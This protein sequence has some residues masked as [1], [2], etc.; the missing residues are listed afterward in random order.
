MIAEYTIQTLRQTILLPVPSIIFK[1]DNLL[2]KNYL[3]NLNAIGKI[4]GIIFLNFKKIIP[5]IFLIVLIIF[6]L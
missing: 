6:Y 1:P 4:P 2:I 3:I 5:G